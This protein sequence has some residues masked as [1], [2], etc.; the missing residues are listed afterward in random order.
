VRNWW[1][2]HAARLSSG[3]PLSFTDAGTGNL[4]V[5][6]TTPLE[7]GGFDDLPRRE[8]W[9][10]GYRLQRAGI[11]VVPAL[12]AVVTHGA[13]LDVANSLSDRM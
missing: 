7:L 5:P 1:V 11:R 9:E 6:R 2:D 10:L 3:L 4:S 8:D 12:G 13:D